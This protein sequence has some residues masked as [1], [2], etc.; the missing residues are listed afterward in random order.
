M[1]VILIG[2]YLNAYTK[3]VGIVASTKKPKLKY[4]HVT[5][6]RNLLNSYSSTSFTRI[7][8]CFVL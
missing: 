7:S 3:F 4:L 2:R 1:V 6:V 8:V 5:T